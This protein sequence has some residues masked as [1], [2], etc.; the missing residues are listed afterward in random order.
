MAERFGLRLPR[1]GVSNASPA[2]GDAD[3]R[4][5][6][7]REVAVE[8]NQLDLQLY[9]HALSVFRSRQARYVDML[10]GMSLQSGQLSGELNFARRSIL[11]AISLPQRRA[12]VSLHGWLLVD[13][14]PADAVLVDGGEGWVP[15]MA[16]R[17]S[18]HAAWTTRSPAYLYAGVSGQVLVPP[19]AVELTVEAYDRTEGRRASR[20]IP[21]HRRGRKSRQKRIGIWPSG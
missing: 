15:L 4:S 21:I 11:D 17:S 9:E 12:E 5:D 1:F 19:Q 2:D 7:F 18:T 3:L 14:R 6:E 10:R 8:H 13:G 16:R 20:T